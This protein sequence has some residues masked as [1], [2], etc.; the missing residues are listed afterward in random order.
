MDNAHVCIVKAAMAISSLF[1]SQRF[2]LHSQFF[3]IE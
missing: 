2:T 1:L 3:Y